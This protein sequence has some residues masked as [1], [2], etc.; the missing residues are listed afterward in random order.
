MGKKNSEILSFEN[1]YYY[2]EETGEFKLLRMGIALT[3]RCSLKCKLCS[4]RVPYMKEKYHPALSDLNNQ[5]NKYFET[6]DYTNKIEVSG[7]EVFM[8]NDF[9]GFLEYLYTFKK[10]FGL[11]RIITNATIMP[12]EQL[13]DVMK[14]YSDSIDV[15][16]DNY[17]AEL[18]TKTYDMEKVLKENNI[19]AIIRNYHKDDAYM[20]GWVDF[21]DLSKVN[22]EEE[23]KDLYSRCAVPQK[24]GFCFRLIDGKM[25]PCQVIRQSITLGECEDTPEE[26]INLFDGKNK[27]EQ[28]KKFIDLMNRDVFTACMYCKGMCDDSERFIPAEQL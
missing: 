19:K 21:G 7:G 11:V 12:T 1:P 18:S 23:A 3:H 2:N 28:N 15:L 4:E 16:I 9:L 13:I 10:Q 5:V 17:G 14:K 20:D 25:D 26:Y 6:V 8:Y 24:I 22:N 27:A